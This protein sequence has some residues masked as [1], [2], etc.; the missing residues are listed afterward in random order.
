MFTFPVAKIRTETTGGHVF[1]GKEQI[2]SVCAVP[3]K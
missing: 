2:F 1:A 3:A